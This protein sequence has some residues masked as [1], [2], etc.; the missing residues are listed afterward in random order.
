MVAT[1][2]KS[3]V[4]AK[5]NADIDSSLAKRYGVAGFPT[6][7]ITKPSGAEL[8]RLVGYYPPESFIPALV[9]LLTNRNTLD[10][11]LAQVAKHPDSLELLN[12]VAENYSYR[13][14]YK[15]AT[16]YYQMVMESDPDNQLGM[17]DDAWI[18]LAGLKRRQGETEEAVEMYSQLEEKYPDSDLV[19]TSKIMVPYTYMRAEEFDKAEKHFKSFKKMYPDS[20]QIE[21]VDKQLEKIKEEKKK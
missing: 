20:E 16:Y 14:N 3:M 13:S 7:V 15:P 18:A 8:D 21:W 12:Q 5:L 2:S 6:M 4:F 17:A 19:K 11:L 10:Y 1:V 9:D